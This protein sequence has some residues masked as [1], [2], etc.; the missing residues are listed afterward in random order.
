[1][2]ATDEELRYVHEGGMDHVTYVL[3]SFRYGAPNT[4]LRLSTRLAHLTPSSS[5][6]LFFSRMEKKN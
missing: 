3:I 4:I 6:F 5:F 2:S 1:M